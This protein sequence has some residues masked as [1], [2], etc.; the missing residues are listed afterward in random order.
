MSDLNKVWRSAGSR[1][2]RTPKSISLA[3]F[4]AEQQAEI[5]RFAAQV[6]L[7]SSSRPP[8]PPKATNK[9]SSSHGS[10]SQPSRS[11]ND[12]RSPLAG[13]S[14]IASPM[15]G[16][17]SSAIGGAVSPS[18]ATQSRV[19]MPSTS[20]RFAPFESLTAMDASCMSIHDLD[21]SPTKRRRPLRPPTAPTRSSR[22]PV[23]SDTI[24]EEPFTHIPNPV[25]NRIVIIDGIIGISR[26]E[27]EPQ[28]CQ[29]APWLEPE[30]IDIM[31][32]GGLR[33]KCKTPAEAERLLKRDGF[34]ADVFGG[35]FNVHRP[36][37][38][39]SSRPISK[40]YERDQRS[41]I[42][43]KIP[44]C[45]NASDAMGCLDANYVEE[46]RDIPPRDPNRPP[47]RIITFR[48]KEMRD[49]AMQ[50]G[51]KWF[52]RRIKVRPLR[53]PV[54][55][56]LCRKCSK[57]GHTAVDCKQQQFTC[58]KCGGSHSTAT[59]QT[60]QRDYRCPNCPQGA[61]HSANYRG[62]PAFKE[63]ATVE[64]AQR[65]A[66]L[67]AKL[68][69]L[70]K[71]RPQNQQRAPQRSSAPA[72]IRPGVSYATAMQP[73]SQQTALPAQPAPPASND[74]MVM[75]LDI[76]KQLS[77]LVSE[78]GKI[79]DRLG[80]IETDQVRLREHLENAE[81]GFEQSAMDTSRM[82]DSSLPPLN[83]DQNTI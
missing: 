18:E 30:T 34:P 47:L 38:I 8:I 82:S 23:S 43:S 28:L 78:Q 19:S 2:P 4:T 15:Q 5:E 73:T 27:L 64:I 71:R 56:L 7:Q 83:H 31:R 41:A 25:R 36:G 12:T 79:N 29:A 33:I 75:L 24:A 55:P 77:F 16:R 32:N 42:T 67:D 46:I 60:Q 39:D 48:T 50:S 37:S 35:S 22:T 65:Q 81:L 10:A 63:A 20:N 51:L 80:E 1:S 13:H 76:K 11:T 21:G 17:T 74:L 58:A 49:E 68:A 61:S 14:N 44:A 53:P 52:N 54:L 40:Q 3:G 69:K 45:Y 6:R 9:A 70:D 62:C 59:C 66:R 26:K 57:Y 72:P